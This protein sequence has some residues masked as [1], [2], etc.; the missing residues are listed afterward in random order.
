MADGDKTAGTILAAIVFV[1]VVGGIIG[2]IFSSFEDDPVPKNRQVLAFP[3]NADTVTYA[4]RQGE[5]IEVQKP[6]GY[7]IYFPET[8]RGLPDLRHVWE[9]KTSD[10]FILKAQDIGQYT[11][12]KVPFV[13]CQERMNRTV[14]AKFED[15]GTGVIM[16]GKY[17]LPFSTHF[18]KWTPLL[19]LFWACRH[20]KLPNS[21]NGKNYQIQYK[22]RHP[23]AGSFELSPWEDYYEGQEFPY[24]YM[25][26]KPLVRYPT[27]PVLELTCDGM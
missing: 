6:D 16:S 9:L 4:L 17:T 8:R 25:R 15:D 18:Q 20:Y 5:Q 21:N 19:H 22:V 12:R 2:S 13:T 11:F 1:A 3:D 23:T 24:S 10:S 7:C 27:D 26:F 14:R